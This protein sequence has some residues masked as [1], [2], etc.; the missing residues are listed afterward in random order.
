LI[1][2]IKVGKG[3]RRHGAPWSSLAFSSKYRETV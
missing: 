3:A 1:T 2:L